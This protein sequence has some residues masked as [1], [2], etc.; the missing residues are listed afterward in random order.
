MALS[1]SDLALPR[2][3]YQLD[4]LSFNGGHDPFGKERPADLLLWP[5][6]KKCPVQPPDTLTL[7]FAE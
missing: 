3:F 2:L 4:G 5:L 7:A 1:D 6:V